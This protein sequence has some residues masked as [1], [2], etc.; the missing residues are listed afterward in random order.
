MRISLFYQSLLSDWNHGNAHF[1]RGYATELILRG[2]EVRIF[3]PEDSWCYKNMI[4]DHGESAVKEFY[5]FYPHLDSIRYN[6]EEIDLEMI[7][8]ETDLAIVHEWNTHK[9]VKDIGAVRKRN[10]NFRLLF[11]DTHHRIISEKDEMMKYDLRYYDGVLAYGKTIKDIYLKEGLSKKVWVW[12]E[13]ADTKVFFPM[14][15]SYSEGEL[16]W[17]GNWGD[18]ERADEL[19]EFLIRP[20]KELRL[21][22]TVYGVR[23]PEHVIKLI[24][25]A[26]IKYSGWLPNYKVPEVFS[27]YTLTVHIPRRP[28]I[29]MLPGIPTIRPFEALACGIPMISSP[30]RDLEH[31]FRPGKDFLFAQN[32]KEMIRNIEMLLNNE[33]QQKEISSAGLE[34]I[35]ENHTCSH[36]I[37]QLYSICEELGLEILHITRD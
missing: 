11:H 13:A 6:P 27:N 37:D 22:C 3:E 34:T 20:V 16:V 21:K 2:N 36:R 1:L 17:I 9:L 24:E 14:I 30:W 32:G 5:N 35:V 25:N 7:L 12:H 28:Y 10:N 33:Q 26:G 8:N 29:Q 23:Y 15:K 4:K 18:N 31:L 19:N